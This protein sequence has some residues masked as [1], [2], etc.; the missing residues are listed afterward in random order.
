MAESAA[1]QRH[2]FALKSEIEMWWLREEERCGQLDASNKMPA[3]IGGGFN[4]IRRLI[5]LGLLWLPLQFAVPR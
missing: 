4:G 1:F 3:C 5:Y 2:L